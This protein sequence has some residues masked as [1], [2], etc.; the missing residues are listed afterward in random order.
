MRV[1]SSRERDGGIDL[2]I[3]TFAPASPARLRGW[4]TSFVGGHWR[5]GCAAT[6]AV[7][8]LA[9]L[10]AGAA[11]SATVDPL[12]AD[13][14]GSVLWFFDA[15]HRLRRV[16]LDTGRQQSFRVDLGDRLL[17][18]GSWVAV[19]RG[20]VGTDVINEDGHLILREVG[21][22]FAPLVDR[23]GDT[24]W[25]VGAVDQSRMI[26]PWQRYRPPNP[27]PDA[28]W[29]DNWPVAVDGDRLLLQRDLST[30]PLVEWA[31]I[32]ITN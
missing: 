8:M 11:S 16:D 13:R 25:A 26:R 15:F 6:L 24:L 19:F 17:E 27:V 12:L 10:C 2:V 1:R 20:G 5:R 7:L 28:E 29:T 14:T 31:G 9:V 30:G 4:S 3:E 23:T 32:A 22:G 21:E 18:M